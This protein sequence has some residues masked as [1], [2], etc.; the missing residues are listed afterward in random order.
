MKVQIPFLTNFKIIK[1][2]IDAFNIFM[3]FWS[4]TKESMNKFFVTPKTKDVKLTYIRRSAVV[5]DVFWTSYVRSIYVLCLRGRGQE[6]NWNSTKSLKSIFCLSKLIQLVIRCGAFSFFVNYIT[7][8]I[9][10]SPKLSEVVFHLDLMQLK[11]PFVYLGL[12][13]RGILR[14]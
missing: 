4:G 6:L 3:I 13:K 14:D 9:D 5:L 7:N 10:M 11:L 2:K 8:F 12:K 1:L